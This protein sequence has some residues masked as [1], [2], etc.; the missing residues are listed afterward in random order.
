MDGSRDKYIICR[1]LKALPLE[2]WTS[3]IAS[4]N[5][6]QRNPRV[7]S[8]FH[9]SLERSLLSRFDP[10]GPDRRC[11]ATRI[12]YFRACFL[13]SVTAA[14]LNWLNIQITIIRIMENFKFTSAIFWSRL[15]LI[16]MLNWNDPQKLKSKEW[17]C[18]KDFGEAHSCRMIKS[19]PFRFEA[20]M[21]DSC[22]ALRAASSF[23]LAF[24]PSKFDRSNF[25]PDTVTWAD[26]T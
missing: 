3:K 21:R 26:Y 24:C 12:Q 25:D 16:A 23:C 10:S 14:C 22:S 20:P 19:K 1:S 13:C 6:S 7:R 15:N 4:Q 17:L 2:P 5:A 18:C 8:R 9:G 11:S